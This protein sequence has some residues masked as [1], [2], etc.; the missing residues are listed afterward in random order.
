[1]T[2]QH[3]PRRHAF[4]DDLA[5]IR[6]ESSLPPSPHRKFVG[7]ASHVVQEPVLD[8]RQRPEDD[9]PLLTQALFGEAVDVFDSHNGWAWG[10]LVGDGYVG[11]MP[12]RGLTRVKG[13][14]VPAAPLHRVL[15]PRL[16]V[17]S[18]PS[19]LSEAWFMLPMNADV[20]VLETR[21]DGF[22]QLAGIGFVG[23]A[24]I[25]RK[26]VGFCDDYVAIAERFLGVPYLYGGRS[27]LQGLDCSALVQMALCAS[28]V[29]VARDSDMQAAE[30][31]ER[32]S[33][34]GDDL[35]GLKRGDLVFWPGHVAIMRS[36]T[37]VVHANATHMCVTIEPLDVVA[38]RSRKRVDQDDG[39]IVSAVR[40]WQ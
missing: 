32:V 20:E 8:V 15:V 36:E 14:D 28:G 39:P 5:D 17:Y 1:M 10:Q 6:L 13:K 24:Y 38:A 22:S 19:A 25:A 35:R 4:R 34:I 11:Y 33:G 30:V 9:A 29:M 23:S 18:A 21:D 26:G 31:G 40:R 37:E 27:A 2:A 3:D 16:Q 7:G 12:V